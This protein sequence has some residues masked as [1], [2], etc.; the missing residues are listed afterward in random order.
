MVKSQSVPLQSVHGVLVSIT[1]SQPLLVPVKMYFAS[2][3]K[4]TV[5]VDCLGGF[6]TP[7]GLVANCVILGSFSTSTK[8]GSLSTNAATNWNLFAGFI[9]LHQ[10][11]H[12]KLQLR[13]TL[14]LERSHKFTFQSLD[15]D[16]R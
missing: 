1:L 2:G 13:I 11:G 12:S 16:S 8:T 15:D 14:Q 6:S 7:Y 5:N 9:T 10:T 4:L 3:V